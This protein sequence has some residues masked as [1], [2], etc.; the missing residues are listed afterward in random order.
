MFDVINNLSTHVH[1]LCLSDLVPTC[2]MCE[3][4]LSSTL[5]PLLISPDG[6]W[7]GT[8]MLDER[9]ISN[10]DRSQYYIIIMPFTIARTLHLEMLWTSGYIWYG[11]CITDIMT[12]IPI[13]MT[14][15]QKQLDSTDMFASSSCAVLNTFVYTGIQNGVP[16]EIKGARNFDTYVHICENLS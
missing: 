10:C 5:W 3:L 1:E 12:R 13:V 6:A 8:C 4:C 11:V 16:Y 2:G 7:Y 9:L 15:N 14:G